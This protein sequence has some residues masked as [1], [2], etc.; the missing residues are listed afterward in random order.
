VITGFNTDVSY[1]GVTYHVQTEDK[2]V[3]TALILSLV[4]ER[5]VILAAKRSPYDDLVEAGFDIKVLEERL[6]RQH[7]LICAAIRAGRLEDLKKL[8]AKTVSVSPSAEPTGELPAR[9]PMPDEEIVWDIPFLESEVESV[10]IG[11]ETEAVDEELS[12]N[13]I[14]ADQ[15][16]IIDGGQSLASSADN[17]LRLKLIGRERFLTGERKNLNVLVCRGTEEATVSGASVMIKILGSDFRPLIYHAR[18]DSNGIAAVMVKI[19]NFR[20][21][22]AA[23]LIRAIVE[24]EEAELRRVVS[25]QE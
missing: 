5:G 1:D 17:R 22:R 19:P 10:E 12:E 18:A 14:E 13:V 11:E 24:G 7:K 3:E 9:I 23:I 4:Y 15:V 16:L 8:S 2:G 21:G 20:S 25:H 6:Q